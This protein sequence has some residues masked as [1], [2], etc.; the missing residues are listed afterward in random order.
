[1]IHNDLHMMPPTTSFALDDERYL[2]CMDRRYR[3]AQ[4]LFNL[5]RKLFP[6]GRQRATDAGSVR[7]IDCGAGCRE[8]VSARQARALDTLV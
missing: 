4:H 1:M 7:E 2:K 3:R 5:F 8:P 6:F